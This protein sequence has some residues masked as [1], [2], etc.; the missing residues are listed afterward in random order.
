VQHKQIPVFGKTSG[1]LAG[2]EKSVRLTLRNEV[3]AQDENG[4]GGVATSRSSVW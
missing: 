1:F 3:K 4:T 2:A